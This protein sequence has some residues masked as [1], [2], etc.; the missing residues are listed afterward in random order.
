MTTPTPTPRR[1]AVETVLL[2]VGF[3][4]VWFVLQMWVLPKMGVST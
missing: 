2:A 1:Q 3:V 4:I